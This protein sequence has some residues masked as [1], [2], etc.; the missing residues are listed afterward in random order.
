MQ[1]VPFRP[2]HAPALYDVYRQVA[3]GVPHCRFVPSA[4]SFA[5]AL[6]TPVQ[7]TELFVA[8]DGGAAVGLAALLQI[9]GRSARPP[10]IEL[11]A[12]FAADEPANQAL[13][14]ACIAVARNHGVDHLTAFDDEHS[15][16]P[17][18]AYN[19]GWSGLSDAMPRAARVL[20]RAGFVPYHRELHLSCPLDRQGPLAVAA[21]LPALTLFADPV[22]D[23]S[24]EHTLRALLGGERVGVC[25]YST[26]AH[27]SDDA[28]ASRWGY[29]VWLHV[30]EAYR[31][32]GVARYL[33]TNA[34]ATLAAAGC[35][36]CW[37]T[38]GGANWPALTLY[39]SLGFE[40]VDTSTCFRKAL[41]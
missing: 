21:H 7:T 20:A 13:V 1:V 8:E 38:T 14:E 10:A 41:G 27:L 11:T 29:I 39:L 15:H 34:L 22:A 25:V 30:E 33:L 37:L 4:A 16:C 19:A 6:A 9:A 40:I 36:G 18:P 32:R 28:A 35:T 5:R 17:I 3:A 31:R 12:L 2:E 26:L 23:R 24:E